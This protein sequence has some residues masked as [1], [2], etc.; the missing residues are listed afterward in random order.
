MAVLSLP[1]PGR[2]GYPSTIPSHVPNSRR[3]GPVYFSYTAEK[4]VGVVT[5]RPLSPTLL[6]GSDSLNKSPSAYV[7][8]DYGRRQSVIIQILTRNPAIVATSLEIG[9]SRRTH[10][11]IPR[12]R[13]LLA[14]YAHRPSLTTWLWSSLFISVHSFFSLFCAHCPLTHASGLVPSLAICIDDHGSVVICLALQILPTIFRSKLHHDYDF[15]LL[16][17]E[18]RPNHVTTPTSRHDGSERVPAFEPNSTHC[19]YANWFATSSTTVQRVFLGHGHFAVFFSRAS[20][21]AYP[22][23]AHPGCTCF[24]VRSSHHKKRTE[25]CPAWADVSSRCLPA[26]ESSQE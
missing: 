20:A 15:Q 25:D 18:R 6:C 16:F 13:Y 12:K 1:V 19:E 8:R 5:D 22:T 24:C 26:L 3:R 11:I 10:V 23:V 4:S 9:P 7:L 14:W 2:K 17:R 21:G